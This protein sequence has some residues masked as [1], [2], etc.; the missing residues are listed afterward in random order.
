METI[1]I[2]E[3]IDRID[4][5][6]LDGAVCL[7]FV[8]E[9]GEL[10]TMWVQKKQTFRGYGEKSNFKYNVREKRV[11]VVQEKLANGTTQDKSIKIARIVKFS[12]KRVIHGKW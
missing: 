10:R 5:S 2:K 3:V 9:G 11:L 12:E 4:L 7:T 8:K 6:G 1:S